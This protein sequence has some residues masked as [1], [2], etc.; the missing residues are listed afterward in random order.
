MTARLRSGLVLFALL[1]L[2]PAAFGPHHEA[3]AQR[4]TA[5]IT[6]VVLDETDQP[7][8]GVNVVAIHQPTGTQYGAA[9]NVEGR[10]TLQGLRI[11]G[12]YTLTASFIGYQGRREEGITLRLGEKR[13][14]D[15][16]LQPKTEEL[17]AVEVVAERNPVIDQTRTGA[18]ISIDEE[19]IQD[20]PTIARS[21][22]DFARLVPQ[23]SGYGGALSF[24]GRNDR[25]NNIQIDGATFNDVFGL[26]DAT[27]GSQ[28]GSQPISLDAIAA[29]NVDIAPYDVRSGN[30][31]GGQVNA[32]TKSGTNEV[33]GLARF[34]GGTEAF[35]GDLNGIGTSEFSQAFY[36]V[37]VGG[38]I[39]KDKLFFFVNGELKRESS[40]LDTRVSDAGGLNTFNLS[41]EAL[42]ALGFES[43]E[44]VLNEISTIADSVYGF[45]PGGIN[46]ISRRQDDEKLLVKLDW[47]VSDNHRATL[48]YNFLNARNDAGLGRGTQT[49]GFASEQYV[50]RNT[51][52]S[53]TAQV[54]STFGD[55][56]LNEGRVTY[57][58][59][60][61][62]R[63]IG[64]SAFPS[65]EI[66]LGQS[67]VNLGPGRFNQANRL[68]QDL[69]E[70]T[71]NLTYLRGNHTLTFG[72]N[73][74]F[75]RFSNL[76]IQDF[77]GTY[78]FQ[79][80]TAGDEQVS[81]LEAFR[82]GQPTEY[83]FSYA[84]PA[85]G[86][87]RPEAEFTAFQLG[88]YVQDEW[89]VTSGLRLT[90]GLR[91]D[92]PFTP[93]EPTQNPTALDQFGLSTSNVATGNLLW[94][95]RLGFNYRTQTL[96]DDLN[97]QVRGGTGLFAGAPPFVWIS[98]QFSN[99]GADLFRLDTDFSPGS[100]FYGD[101][102]GPAGD[103]FV[104][105][106]I[107]QDPTGQPR[108]GEGN[109]LAPEETTE[110][111]LID[112]D[113]KYPRVWRTN[114]AVDQELPYGF[115]ATLEGIYS[116]ST[117]EIL[118]R[119]LNIGQANP[120]DP[121][122]PLP[123]GRSLYGRPFYEGRISDDFTNVLYLTN[124][125]QGYDYSLTAQLQ[126]RVA[127]GLSGSLSYTYGQARSL[128]NGTSSRAISNWQFNENF[129]VNNPRLGDADF[130]VRHRILGSLTYRVAYL[131]DRAA[132][133]LGFVYD[134]RAGEP[135]SWIY[136]GNANGD[137][138][139]DNDL[140]FVPENET[141]IVLTSGNW[142][143]MNA[144]IEGR[145]ELNEAR[146]TVIRRNTGRAPW[147]NVLD[148]RLTQEI[149]TVRGQRVELTVDFQNFLN[150][151]NDDWG[152]IRRP[153]FN[154]A[155]AWG[156]SGYVE[157][158]DVGSQL[159]GRVLTAD[160]VGKPIVSFAEET[161]RDDLSD[162]LF[163]VSNIFSR[164]RMRLGLRYTF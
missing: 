134:G 129:D 160:D 45:N 7:L 163:N 145:S 124:T 147:Q 42:S 61:D 65:V 37:N 153:S 128:N 44:A 115:V 99:T 149:A 148:L 62:E 144:F 18:G 100:D 5:A 152:R 157:D 15:F 82:R 136:D 116:K 68:D 53:L 140:V 119:N 35:T 40:P 88:A 107:G 34:V 60:R 56:L 75:F 94:S 120:D 64:D 26:G 33:F 131:N 154:N 92:V 95:P 71:D 1:L 89:E 150:W 66:E 127:R 74:Q 159:G 50:F 146:G 41:P 106:T 151:L 101:G 69:I 16:S 63:D 27:P 51:T 104:P 79:G 4:T 9:T 161:A 25:F 81:A 123:T 6:G 73:N 84:T 114:I 137:T 109:A 49:F 38:P 117:N 14:I 112:P 93:E 8:P 31:T 28:A 43:T 105:R 142:D 55:N 135:F 19:Q 108:P 102:S 20:L 77:F 11:G 87:A 133:T 23:A 10:Y 155:F 156:I 141:D 21:L 111:N 91:V 113:F 3:R 103:R 96:G 132:T 58:R 126:R 143:L 32:V 59:I 12:P 47:N 17:E 72:T 162:E 90:A 158:D 78:S 164:W 22:Q 70:V 24:G 52:N 48:R 46:P 36:V 83:N 13:V 39:I 130:V 67:T 85:A 125:D 80:F 76:F 98:N 29:L 138:R 86:T 30:F 139:D 54:N 118:Y 122:S 121:T 2:A 110:I 97:V 57:T